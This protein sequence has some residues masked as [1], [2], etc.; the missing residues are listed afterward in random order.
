[1]STRGVIKNVRLRA[2]RGKVAATLAVA[3]T[4]SSV[5]AAGQMSILG[6]AP[7]HADAWK[8]L[9][10][11]RQWADA[12]RATSGIRWWLPAVQWLSSMKERIRR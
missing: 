6:R 7:A 8:R 9:D 1:V 12:A 10:R 5:I 4:A 11:P 3:L 2:L